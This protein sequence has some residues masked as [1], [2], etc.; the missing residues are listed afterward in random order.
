MPARKKLS[1][2]S[3]YKELLK[4]RV[5]TSLGFIH[6]HFII[7]NEDS[8]DERTVGGVKV[9]LRARISDGT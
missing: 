4:D 1:S 9:S 6:A 5:D 3:E 8:E 7:T 2:H